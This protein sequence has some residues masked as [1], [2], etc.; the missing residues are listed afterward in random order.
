MTK[1]EEANLL[2]FVAVVIAL[3]GSVM[4][5]SSETLTKGLRQKFCSDISTFWKTADQFTSPRHRCGAR[6]RR[7]IRLPAA[8]GDLISVAGNKPE[9]TDR[10]FTQFFSVG[11]DAQ[12]LA[13]FAGYNPRGFGPAHVLLPQKKQN[14]FVYCHPSLR[15]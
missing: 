2:L 11:A 14:R 7:H 3:A 13:A 8:L 1:Y 10:I 15:P 4:F 5:V 12:N 6:P 9:V